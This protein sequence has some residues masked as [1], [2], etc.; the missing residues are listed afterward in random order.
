MVR[1]SNG[2]WNP[3]AQPFEIQTNNHHFVKNHLKSDIQKYGFQM[4][5]DF[6]V[7]DFKSSL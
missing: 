6:E 2:V 1:I 5:L 3:E 7:S 4:F